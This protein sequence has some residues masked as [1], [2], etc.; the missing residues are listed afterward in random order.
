MESSNGPRAC[1]AR[2]YFVISVFMVAE[3]CI[4]CGEEGFP[5]SVIDDYRNLKSRSFPI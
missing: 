1:L 3:G 4:R 5:V 2:H